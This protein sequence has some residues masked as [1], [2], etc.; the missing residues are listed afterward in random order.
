MDETAIITRS[1]FDPVISLVLDGLNSEHSKRAYRAALTHF[2]TW[3]ESQGRPALNKAVVQSYRTELQQ[4]GLSAS[5]ANVRMSAVRKLAAEAADNGMMPGEVANGIGRVKGVKSAGVRVGNWLTK[6]QAEALINSPD[7]GTVQGMRD[8]A[9]LAVAIGGGL[10][11]SELAAL[12]FEHIQQRDG[13][14]VIVDL[15]GK[16]NRVRTVPIPSWAKDAVDRWAAAAGIGTGRVFRGVDRW[17][18]LDPKSQGITP[19]VI[20]NQVRH[21]LK[22]ARL[23]GA[24]HDLRR[25]FAHLARKGGADL[26]QIQLS[27]GHASIMTTERY[28]GTRQ[29]LDTAPCDVLGLDLSGD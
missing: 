1:D 24:A 7:L 12:T 3:W 20:Y 23:P 18:N 28:L 6:K 5:A 21:Y 17:G 27:L 16:G 2:L 13:R 26:E 8:R 10:R 25:T 29:N 9:I 22:K 4:R 15:V 11:R 19:Q 14:W